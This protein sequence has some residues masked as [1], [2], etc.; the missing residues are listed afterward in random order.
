MRT[1]PEDRPQV[2]AHIDA[3]TRRWL[4]RYAKV[5]KLKPSELVRL[6]IRREQEIRWLEKC[7]GLSDEQINNRSP[8]PTAMITRRKGVSQRRRA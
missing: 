4:D 3:P 2:T 5:L 8:K 7:I 6:L 1:N